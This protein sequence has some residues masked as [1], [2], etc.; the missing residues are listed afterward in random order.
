MNLGVLFLKCKHAILSL[1]VSQSTRKFPSEGVDELYHLLLN[2][3]IIFC[4]CDEWLITKISSGILI[5][6]GQGK[7]CRTGE[8]SNGRTE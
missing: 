1:A 2:H 8:R 4:L 3:S 5:I 7:Y 6:L